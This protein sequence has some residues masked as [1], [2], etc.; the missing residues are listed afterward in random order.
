MPTVTGARTVA[1]GREFEY[2]ISAAGDGTVP[3]DSA[4]L[5]HMP[6]WYTRTPHSDLP[7]DATVA[8]ATLELLACGRTSLLP[9]QADRDAQSPRRVTDTE[10]HAASRTKVDWHALDADQRRRF[11]E[12]LNELP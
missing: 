4:R 11:L 10:L 6:L 1:E 12:R 8:A 9:D 3:L 2:E 5:G 7:R